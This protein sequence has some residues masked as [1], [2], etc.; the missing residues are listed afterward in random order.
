MPELQELL[1]LHVQGEGTVA[2]ASQRDVLRQDRR[3]GGGEVGAMA[4]V[5][6]DRVQERAYVRQPEAF[7]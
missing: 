2:A 3:Q 1:Q 4:E 5:G 6:G 7:G